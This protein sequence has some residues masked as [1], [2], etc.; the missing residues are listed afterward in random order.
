MLRRIIKKLIHIRK[1]I[2]AG[3]HPIEGVLTIME[4]LASLSDGLLGISTL[5]CLAI[6]FK[7][8]I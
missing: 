8:V 4:N 1:G 7:K 2:E 3:S 5:Y 6:F